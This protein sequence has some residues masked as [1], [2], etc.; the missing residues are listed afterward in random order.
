VDLTRTGHIQGQVWYGAPGSSVSAFETMTET[1]PYSDTLTSP[2]LGSNLNQFNYGIKWTGWIIP[3]ITGAYTFIT[4]SDDESRFYL[5]TDAE[6]SHRSAKPICRIEPGWT[7]DWPTSGQAV[8]ASIPLEAGHRYYFEYYH[9]QGDSWDIGQVGWS[10]P[11]YFSERPITGQYLS[12]YKS[13]P[14][15][16][17]SVVIGGVPVQYQILLMGL[18]A[19][20]ITAQGIVTRPGNASDTIY[21]VPLAQAISFKGQSVSPPSTMNLPV[22]YYDYPSGGVYPEFDMPAGWTGGVIKGMVESTLSESTATDAAFFNRSRIPKPTRGTP[23]PNFGCGVNEWFKYWPATAPNTK[24]YRYQ[25]PS[26]GAVD[27]KDC[28]PKGA[29]ARS[30]TNKRYY[31]VLNFSLDESQGPYTY[32]FSRMGNMATPNPQTS[33][34]GE[35]EFFPLDF[36]PKDP[37]WSA[38]NNSFCVEMHTSFFHQSGLKFEFTGDDDVWVFLDNK[39]VIDLGGMH[40]SE[41]AIVNLDELPWLD[42]GE[43]YAL[44]FFQCERH[45]IHS[46]SR[47][48]TNIKMGRQ[49]GAPVTNWRRDYGTT[50]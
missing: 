21:R 13:D 31:N 22:I 1:S 35:P 38:H 9:K 39:L 17:G 46:T 48:V 8:S 15:W 5:S 16:I 30:Y 33:W 25:N 50:N 40:M 24:D 18:D 45:T 19:F 20:Q 34:R 29:G 43:T 44:D 7:V 41:N 14:Q 32:V 6:E 49:Q 42:Y 12:P 4:R 10:G 23:A 37:D 2:Y 47:I 28:T 3:P 11:E 36:L 27:S 26:T